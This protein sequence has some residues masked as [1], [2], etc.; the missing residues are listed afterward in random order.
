MLPSVS[1]T[2]RVRVSRRAGPPV[3]TW[4][5]QG[6]ARAAALVL[7][8]LP[9]PTWAG[10]AEVVAAE[11]HCGEGASCSFRA[12]VRHADSGW[13]HY[14]DRWE[15]VA[16][17]GRVLATRVLRHP[18]VREQPFTRALRDVAL[19]ASIERVRIRAH[20]SVHGYGGQEQVV[21]IPRR[22]GP[23]DGATPGR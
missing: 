8:S 19:D 12:T 11:V 17:D 5:R 4:L 10:P 18:H 13:D 23:Q 2:L 6:V 15:V 20:D 1:A 21:E 22:D 16:P 14:A 9:T 3:A 7:V